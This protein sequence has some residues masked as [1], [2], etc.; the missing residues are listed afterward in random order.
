MWPVCTFQWIWTMHFKKCRKKKKGHSSSTSSFYSSTSSSSSSSWSLL[1]K[2]N[3]L[4]FKSGFKR[5]SKSDTSILCMSLI[6][7]HCLLLLLLL[8]HSPHRS[9]NAVVVK[10]IMPCTLLISNTCHHHRHNF[11]YIIYIDDSKHFIFLHPG[12][13]NLTCLFNVKSVIIKCRITQHVHVHVGI[14]IVFQK[15]HKI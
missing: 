10:H 14:F 5:N 7:R 15:S 8:L 2:M 9:G 12:L 6:C 11:D 13:V 3:T 1:K 4:K